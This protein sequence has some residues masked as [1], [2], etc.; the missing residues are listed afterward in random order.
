MLDADA[1][2]QRRDVFDAELAIWSGNRNLLAAGELFRRS[3]F[4][5]V[6]VRS[7]S[8]EDRVMRV[9][10]RLQTEHVRA[11]AAKDKI[12]RDVAEVFLK[13]LHRACGY[14]IAAIRDHVTI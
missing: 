8:A 3:T 6:Y 4:V 13:Q 9:R 10:D 5:N 12:D 1:V 2:Q 11:R 7:I 14:R